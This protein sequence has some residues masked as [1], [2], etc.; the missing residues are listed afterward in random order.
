[1][2]LFGFP[3]W[4]PPPHGASPTGVAAPAPAS[5]LLVLRSSFPGEAERAERARLAIP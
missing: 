5:S 4:G 2:I 3:V 1:M